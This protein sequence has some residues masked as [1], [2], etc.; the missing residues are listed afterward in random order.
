[1]DSVADP[2]GGSGDSEADRV[3]RQAWSDVFQADDPEEDDH[4]IDLGGDSL[5][6]KRLIA[7][8]QEVLGCVIPFRTI[9]DA[10]TLGEF[11]A[12]VREICAEL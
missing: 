3:V 4:F 11:T 5:T 6:A 7:A 10:P 9:L 1:M 2:R 12:R 8:I